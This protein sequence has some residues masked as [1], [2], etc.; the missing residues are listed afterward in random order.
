MQFTIVIP[1]RFASTRLPG[2]PLIDISGK[3]MIEWVWR[4]AIDSKASR[5]VVATDDQRILKVCMDIGAEAYLTSEKHPSG[6]DRIAEVATILGLNDDHVIVNLQGDEPLVPVNVIDQ[7]ASN[8]HLNPL[9]EL[10]TLCEPI[11]TDTDLS[12]IHI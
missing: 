8:L 12:L 10:S 9:A 3:P 5:V 11:L 2:K 1:A 7:V 4:R 6:T